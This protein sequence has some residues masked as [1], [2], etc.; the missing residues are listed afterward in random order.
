MNLMIHHNLSTAGSVLLALEQKLQ[1]IH[2]L[3]YLNDIAEII[4]LQTI[5]NKMRWHKPIVG[6]KKK[7]IE[8][9]YIVLNEDYENEQRI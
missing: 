6:F 5:L 4:E 1:G 9:I 2:N 8:R 3:L 7:L